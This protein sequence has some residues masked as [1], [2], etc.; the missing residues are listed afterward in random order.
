MTSAAPLLLPDPPPAAGAALDAVV[1]TAERRRRVR[2][3]NRTS[4]SISKK[5]FMASTDALPF[6]V[7]RNSAPADPATRA[8]ILAD[9]GF[10]VHFS[11]HM[12]TID[13]DID[14]GW[15]DAQ[16]LPYGPLSIYPGA[17]VFHYAQEIFEGLKAYRHADGSIWTFRPDQNAKRFQGSAERLA[18]PELPEA[19]FVQSL[20]E[21]A[22][23]DKAWVPDAEGEKSLYLRPFMFATEQFLGVRSAQQVKYVLIGSPAG[24][25]F[26][27]GVKP[28]DIWLE[29]KLARTSLGGTGEAKCGGNYAASLQPENQAHA[30]GCSQ[31]LFLDT[32][33]HTN[34]DELGGM[35]IMFVTSDN[36]LVT[37]KLT[38][39]I[40]RGVT[41]KSLLQIAEEDFGLTVEE[42]AVSLQEWKDRVADGTFTEIF[43]C[44]TAAVINPLAKLVAEDFTIP[45]PKNTAGEVTMGLRKALTD[46]QYGR[47]ED[48]RGWTVKLAD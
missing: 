19:D 13:Y 16:V 25:Y 12:V 6:S 43:A 4:F 45:A 8:G 2:P 32:E 40:L 27:G 5:D 26:K 36:R 42:R 33:T 10:G 28:V 29:Q 31:V 11:D 3:G 20:F 22:A 23:V 24:P 14:Q 21:L 17:S 38:G 44:G 41:R 46:I 7:H 47:A 9:P 35:N 37:P 1:L 15:H 39:A 18:L 30:H 48:K 34:V